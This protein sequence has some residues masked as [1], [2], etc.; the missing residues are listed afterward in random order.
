MR[1]ESDVG[2]GRLKAFGGKKLKSFWFFVKTLNSITWISVV[3]ANKHYCSSV[4]LASSY[5]TV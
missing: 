5:D 1:E 3:S 4:Q 2:V